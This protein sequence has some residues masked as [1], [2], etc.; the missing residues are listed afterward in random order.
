MKTFCISEERLTDYLEGRLSS[1]L[2][3]R[4]ERHLSVCDRCLEYIQVYRP[5]FAAA[6]IDK[7]AIVPTEA[8]KRVIDGL[9]GLNKGCLWDRLAGRAR[10]MFLQ[11]Q[12]LVEQFGMMGSAALQPIRG[13]K[14]VVAD[15]LVM[16]RK[17]FSGLETEISLEK[18]DCGL[19]NVNVVIR[20]AS[21]DRTPVRVSLV[22]DNRELASYLIGLGGAYFESVP[23]GHY[24]LCFSQNGHLIGQ[25]GFQI[26]ESGNGNQETSG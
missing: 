10:A 14:T 19:A 2:R 13:D 1:R 16:L 26:K 20:N 4:V 9:D 5:T 17:T 6:S 7:S 22:S 24:T 25:Y 23:F 3:S 12:R 18:I 15:D 11:W 8:T 21:P